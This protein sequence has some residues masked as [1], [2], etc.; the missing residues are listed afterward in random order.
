MRDSVKMGDIRGV[1]NHHKDADTDADA[2]TEAPALAP[3]QDDVDDGQSSNNSATAG[4]HER[5]PDLVSFESCGLIINFLLL[6]PTLLLISLIISS[7]VTDAFPWKPRS[8]PFWLAVASLLL[9]C[10]VYCHACCIMRKIHYPMEDEG[11]YDSTEPVPLLAAA[12]STTRQDASSFQDD[13]NQ[14]SS[15]DVEQ[16]GVGYD[17]SK[18]QEK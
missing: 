4:A 6:V 12:A 9:P 18:W 11:E 1:N 8:F 17:I 16:A 5:A 14:C 10:I 7:I 2:H 15:G 13:E 3:S